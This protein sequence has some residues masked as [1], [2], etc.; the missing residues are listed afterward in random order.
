MKTASYY[1][2]LPDKKVR[3]ELCPHGCLLTDRKRGICLTRQNIDGALISLNYCR[4]VSTAIDPIEKKPL[5]HFHPG[6]DIFSTGPNGCTFKCDFCQNCDISQRILPTRELKPQAFASTIIR[7]KTAGVA[8]TYSEPY[9]WYETI[10]DIGSKV[11]EAG[12]CN[13]MVTNGYMNPAPL[14]DLL[15]VVDAMNVDIKSMDERFYKRLCKGSLKPV[16]QSCETIKKHAHLEITNLLITG[17]ND[18]E[19]DVA[20][21]VDYIAGNLGADTPLHISRYFPRH[22]FSA[23]PTDE[24]S[25]IRAWEIASRKLDYVYLGN[26]Y[27]GDKESTYCPS[28]KALLIERSGYRVRLA[29]QLQK[30]ADAKAGCSA[31]GY[32]V[33]IIM[34]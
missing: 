11:K 1:A 7:S 10:M 18:S 2:Q 5:Y 22:K 3:C 12:M 19:K 27:A 17:E 14:K 4:P 34:D 24:I 9:I 13:V 21:L 25:L 29:P 8:Y 15:S 16:L 32:N 31:C 26:M 28:C 23:S 30:G 20:G 33:N 6:T